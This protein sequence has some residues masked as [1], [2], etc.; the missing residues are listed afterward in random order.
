MI[1]NA[2]GHA[3]KHD[4]E[5][6]AADFAAVKR[7]GMIDALGVPA[8]SIFA[9][10][11][12]F[13]AI[14]RAAGF[15]ISQ[16]MVTSALVWGMPG[17][18]AM[19]SLHMAGA[20]AMVIFTAVALANMRMLLMV[21]S[22]MDMTGLR[23]QP[24]PFWKKMGLMQMLAITSWVHIGQVEDK[25]TKPQL[26]R[27]FTGFA[28]M[29]YIAGIFGTGF[30]YYLSDYVSDDVLRVILAITPMYILMMV[31]T[32]RQSLNRY[33]GLWGGVLCP[34]SYP[35]IGEWGILLGGIVGGTMV[36]LIDQRQKKKAQ[37]KEGAHHG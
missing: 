10:M 19:A 13:S 29:I 9:N 31:V 8:F 7:R 16:A 20:S 3:S 23:D 27:Y 1:D 12:G 17:Q 4:S 37:N 24:M 33:A 22:G 2:T 18:V 6:T 21:V 15:D 11:T 34:L 35:L 28:S 25:Y 5:V 14:A 32:A 36:V 26:L 30:G